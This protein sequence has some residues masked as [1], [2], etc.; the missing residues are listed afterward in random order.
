MAD[1]QGAVI[2]ASLPVRTK[3][4]P[5]TIFS[6]ALIGATTLP[7]IA[8]ATHLT[9]VAPAVMVFLML[10][11]THVGATTY[12]FS[13]PAIRQFCVA[14]PVKMIAIPCAL[15]VAVLAIFSQ[16]GPLFTCAALAFFLLQTW[17]FG[18]QNIGVASFI[19]LSDRGRPLSPAEKVAIRAG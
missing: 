9:V 10:G 5:Q 16:P 2:E 12:L 11:G 17:H 1:T 6:W 7:F 4:Q 18:A 3:V 13:D 15:L 19:S 14:N 8:F